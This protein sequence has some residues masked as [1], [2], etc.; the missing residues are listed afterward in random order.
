MSLLKSLQNSLTCVSILWI[1]KGTMF[2]SVNFLT[3]QTNMKSLLSLVTALLLST[4]CHAQVPDQDLTKTDFN[5]E[6][7]YRLQIL[8]L[9]AEIEKDIYGDFSLVANLGGVPLY[10]GRETDFNSGTS[11]FTIIPFLDLQARYYTNFNR[12]LEAGKSIENNSGNFISIKTTQYFRDFGNLNTNR[13]NLIGVAYGIQRTYWDHWH[14]NFEA[15]VFYGRNEF[16]DQF[17]LPIPT[18]QIGYTF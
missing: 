5:N 9:G 18:F 2:D 15:G 3:N 1:H 11:G 13:A 10:L 4:F 16:D 6:T 8:P 17:V 7:I 12:R 14:L